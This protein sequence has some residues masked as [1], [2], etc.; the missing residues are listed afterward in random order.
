MLAILLPGVHML[1]LGARK[2]CL[3][4][5]GSGQHVPR[6]RWSFWPWFLLLLGAGYLAGLSNLPMQAGFYLSRSAMDRLAAE[7]LSN[8]EKCEQLVGRWA[9]VYPIEGIEVIGQTVV[10]YTAH[11]RGFYGFL[12]APGARS[13]KIFYDSTNTNEHHFA[14]FPRSDDRIEGDRWAQRV[15]GEWFVMY[16]V[17]WR[18]KDGWS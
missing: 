3:A 15:R 18:I 17:Y 7:A 1:Q 14:E 13:D 11:D 6:A 8:P 5:M 10:L 16:S 12:R 2:V 9:G 4:A